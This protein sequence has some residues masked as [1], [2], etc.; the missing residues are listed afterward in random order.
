MTPAL[1]AALAVAAEEVA[2][3]IRHED[4][5]PTASALAEVADMLEHLSNR[6]SSPLFKQLKRE[7]SSSGGDGNKRELK[8]M[9]LAVAAFLFMAGNT[10]K[11]ASEIAVDECEFS[12][13]PALMRRLK[14]VTDRQSLE[15]IPDWS[16]IWSRI[17]S[18]CTAERYSEFLDKSRR[19]TDLDLRVF[20]RLVKQATDI[21]MRL[22]RAEKTR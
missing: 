6:A 16:A 15:K 8:E 5:K 2:A 9:V 4:D 21:R 12:S 13:V 11:R 22:P 17:E 10:K 20:S 7:V 18:A 3:I 1:K 14:G 19:D